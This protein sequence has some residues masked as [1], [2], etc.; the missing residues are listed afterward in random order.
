MQQRVSAWQI[1][2]FHRAKEE[3]ESDFGKNIFADLGI[4]GEYEGIGHCALGYAVEPAKSS[5]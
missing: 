2:G 1:S 5:T 4:E 3:F